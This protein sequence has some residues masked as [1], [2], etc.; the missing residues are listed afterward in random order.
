MATT[1]DDHGRPGAGPWASRRDLEAE[2]GSAGHCHP[3]HRGAAGCLD[4]EPAIAAIG[5]GRSGEETRR[6]RPRSDCVSALAVGSSRRSPATRVPAF[7][8]GTAPGAD[9]AA[10]VAFG[11]SE[12]NPSRVPSKRVEPTAFNS[13]GTMALRSAA[14]QLQPLGGQEDLNG[15]DASIPVHPVRHGPF[16]RTGTGRPPVADRSI[17]WGSSA[18]SHAGLDRGSDWRDWPTTRRAGF[19]ARLFGHR[20]RTRSVAASGGSPAPHGHSG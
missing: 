13:F 16:R 12:V 11:I 20:T 14:A 17:G 1:L 8:H 7:S 10:P 3:A 4:F 2:G 9:P 6:S 19:G 18:A 5:L 15:H